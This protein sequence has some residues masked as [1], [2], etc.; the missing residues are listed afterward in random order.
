M[1]IGGRVGSAR[2]AATAKA[3]QE[4]LKNMSAENSGAKDIGVGEGEPKSPSSMNC[5]KNLTFED[6]KKKS[7]TFGGR[8]RLDKD[9]QTDPIDE[10]DEDEDVYPSILNTTHPM[11]THYTSL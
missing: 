7:R 8:S 4:E 3:W 1:T 10:E 6:T 2:Q 9:V 5:A 11:I